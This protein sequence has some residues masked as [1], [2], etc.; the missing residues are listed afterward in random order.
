MNKHLMNRRSLM[1]RLGGAGFLAVPVFRGVLLDEAR[2]A[3]PPRLVIVVFAGGARYN[4]PQGTPQMATVHHTQHNFTWEKNMAPLVP[5]RNDMRVLKSIG[6]FTRPKNI[7]GHFT[8]TLLTGDSRVIDP[9]EGPPRISPGMNSIDQVIAAQIG[10]TSRFTSL[11]LGFCTEGGDDP[12]SAGR[13]SVRNGSILAPVTD[14]KIAFS[15]LFSGATPASASPP[16]SA[17]SAGPSPAERDAATAMQR[18]HDRKKSILDLRK[19]EIAEI[20]AM[21]GN[22]ERAKLDE[23][24]TGIRELEKGLPALGSSVGTGTSP[25]A[26]GAP[27]APSLASRACSPPAIGTGGDVRTVSAAMNELVFQAIN[28]DLTRVITL[29]MLE[30]GDTSADFSFLG[31]KRRHHT[32]QHEPADDLDTTQ[33]WLMSQVAA[34]MKRFKDTNEGGVPMLDNLGLVVLSEQA[35]GRDHTSI[36]T[37]GFLAGKA[38]GAFRGAGA[39]LVGN[40]SPLN[41]LWVGLARAYGVD[42]STFGEPKFNKSP[43]SLG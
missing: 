1:R 42:I 26:S 10:K 38:G 12:I 18:L 19:A 3:P 5:Y 43:L 24:L 22:A 41:D 32:M 34:L 6:D 21:T 33:T 30:S 27:A 28:C 14:P 36:P 17:S 7:N 16:P 37:L 23:H 15:R 40:A 35:D 20:K 4:T 29:Q 9:N 11:Q 13:V 31:V 25:P 39:D 8:L 2:A